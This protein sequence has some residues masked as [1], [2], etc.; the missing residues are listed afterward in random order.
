[1]LDTNPWGNESSSPSASQRRMPPLTIFGLTDLDRHS[2]PAY[3]FC[4]LRGRPNAHAY[5]NR[6]TADEYGGN[7]GDFFRLAV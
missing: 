1:M 6:Q 4:E 3:A 5:R 7:T 2:S